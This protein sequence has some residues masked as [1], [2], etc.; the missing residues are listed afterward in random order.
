MRLDQIP[1]HT[2]RKRT[3]RTVVE[4]PRGS[5]TKFSYDPKLQAMVLKKTLPEGMVFPYDF[6]FIPSTR[7]EDGDPLDVLILMDVCTCPGCV[8]ECRLIGLIKAQQKEKGGKSVRNDR[9]IAV[10]ADSLVYQD[11]ADVSELPSHFM[12]QLEEFFIGYN[13]LSQK[14]FKPLGVLGANAAWKRLKAETKE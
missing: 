13:K 8:I 3:I 9:Y 10:E 5:R 14:S 12:E 7:G 4:T 1:A 11:I 6:G 2:D